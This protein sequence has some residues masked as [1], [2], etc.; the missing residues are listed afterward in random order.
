MNLQPTQI[1]NINCH[2]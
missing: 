1:T 2:P